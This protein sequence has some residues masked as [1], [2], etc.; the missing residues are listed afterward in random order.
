MSGKESH[1]LGELP[2]RVLYFLMS[3]CSVDLCTVC[4]CILFSFLTHPNADHMFV[5]R[6]RSHR[7]FGDIEPRKAFPR[8]SPA[9]RLRAAAPPASST[10]RRRRLPG[11]HTLGA[12]SPISGAPYLELF[13]LR[14]V[15]QTVRGVAASRAG[16]SIPE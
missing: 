2:G 7:D 4:Y 9:L 1:P 15:T 12:D 8:A 10:A 3:V 11:K 5:G 16:A 6:P 13:A 14:E